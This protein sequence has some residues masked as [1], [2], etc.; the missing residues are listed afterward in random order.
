M[1]WCTD[2]TSSVDP[3][4]DARRLAAVEASGLMRTPPQEE[5]DRLTEVARRALDADAAVLNLLD[6]TVQFCKSA[7]DPA[8]LLEAG[9]TVPL[10]RTICERV[11]VS[12]EPVAIPDVRDA[13]W[14]TDR[15]TVTEGRVEA[16]LGVPL[17]ARG[18]E[19]IG[20]LCALAR[21][22]RRWSERDVGV[23]QGIA[24]AIATEIRLHAEIRARERSE[25]ALQES[26]TRLRLLVEGVRGYAIF[27]LD[28]DGTIRSWNAG[29][30]QILGY[31]AAEALGRPVDLF[32]TEEERGHA[33]T[34]LQQAREHGRFEEEGWRQ[35]RDGALV[36]VNSTVTSV[37]DE[38]GRLL[39]FTKII[40]DLSERRRAEEE[41]ASLLERLGRERAR[42]ADV[43]ESAPAFLSVVRGPDH[44]FEMANAAYYRLVGRRNLLGSPVHE[45]LP[46]VVEQGFVR[47][48][49]GVRE[50]GTPFVGSEMS[51]QLRTR[52]GGPLQQR[53]V[54]FVFQPLMD[55]EAEP[56]GILIHGVDVTEIVAARLEIVKAA[57][58][59]EVDVA[60]LEAILQALPVGVFVTDA[61]G[62]VTTTNPA[63]RE[64]WGGATPL[65]A[66]AE[67]HEY[68][69]WD[70]E[71]GEPVG[72]D[73][74]A[75]TRALRSGAPVAEHELEIE[76]F[77]GSRKTIVVSGSVFHGPTGE[78]AGAIAVNRDV[79]E[80]KRI[81]AVLQRREALLKAAGLAATRFLRTSD[82]AGEI[83]E[84]LQRIGEAA[85]VDRI[86]LF[87]VTGE[88]DG[89]AV[90]RQ[91]NEW[92]A[93]DIPPE[94]GAPALQRWTY[95]DIGVAELEVAMRAGEERQL[96][97]DDIGHE[98]R[99]FWT[100]RGIHSI[101][102]VPIHVGDRWWG[103]LGVD[104]CRDGRIWPESEREVFRLL[105]EVIGAA[106]GREA[107]ESRLA[108]I[109]DSAMDAVISVDEEQRIR[110]FNP[111]AER[112]LGASAAEV[113]G[114]HLGR[115]LPERHRARHDALVRGFDDSGIR[116]RAMGAHGALVAL[117]ADGR[118]IPIEA[119]ISR[120]SAGG[121][122]LFT[123][124]LRDVSEQRRIE[125]QLRQSQK[126][127]AVGRLAGG[128]AHDFNNMLTA[129]SGHAQLVLD[130]I[131]PDDPIRAD[132]DEI[133]KAADRSAEL[134]RQ[135]LAFSRKQILKPQ[136]LD[137][138][139][140]VAGMKRM[141]GRLIGEDIELATVLK[142]GTPKVSADRG[143][144]EQILM[145]LI[146]NSR[147][148]MPG[149]GKLTIG[150]QNAVLDAEYGRAHDVD[151]APGSYVLL[152]VS[153]TGVGM[154]AETK[155]HIFEPFFTTKE[156]GKGTGLG[157]ATVYGIVKQSGGY[158]WVYSE[159]GQ[160]TTFKIYLPAAGQAGA[161]EAAGG[162]T[163][164]A[165]PGTETLLLVEDEPAVRS[166]I[167]R[168]LERAGYTVLSAANG[169]DALRTAAG[170]G[171]VIDLL[172]TDVV[173]PGMTGKAVAERLTASRP[174]M[175][176]LYMS[177][178]TDDAIVQ[179]GVL[180]AGTA[181]IQKPLAPAQLLKKVR[182]VLR[183][184]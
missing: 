127:E 132:L 162:A 106:V 32:H 14:T 57:G 133:L 174:E 89:R 39:G 68:R 7:D 83:D 126:M 15:P 141:L 35:R 45:A 21:S 100:A 24:D 179:H 121:E 58:E 1:P 87:R 28:A 77:D 66:A 67:Y 146:V 149:G 26:E 139:D 105:A 148:A 55:A 92:A 95:A 94:L 60:R 65:V 177:G 43:F 150:T 50:T 22:P 131:A 37:A 44:V 30:E 135:L 169:E 3:L 5:F 171:A 156:V 147:D 167:C 78:V 34:I 170:H 151:F 184:R 90:L 31:P 164:S 4:R 49:D 103:V 160:G 79:T 108:G 112:I 25:A 137:L 10:G 140:V 82:W 46:E 48:L 99:D 93:P 13:E 17:R 59:A 81:E 134:T 117:R 145:N 9:D 119:S 91:T 130:D 19:V 18:G 107:T 124:I 40:R 70:V 42:L 118:E 51:I 38:A 138:A 98:V 52:P 128:V 62:V 152:S 144:I 183:A 142:P 173:M 157:L 53:Y 154:D 36:W 115:F 165:P 72:D 178:Y 56:G 161:A 166:L 102:S 71:S 54:S 114:A 88:T 122:K 168:V 41:R 181:F 16:Y 80:E 111:A 47:I 110:V 125:A 163:S 8:E 97:V 86:H 175:R 109:I 182:E 172:L 158:V 69:A 113:I 12:G 75:I 64:I 143:Q 2:P 176:V 61:Q 153:D 136:L 101:L 116:A 33:A 27:A 63:A 104:D 29:A 96:H 11:V 20:A 76:A 120:T 180:E 73:D 6:A 85:D 23:L 123:V 155:K 74:W 159:P 129:I 84:V